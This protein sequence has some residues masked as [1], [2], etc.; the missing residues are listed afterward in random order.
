M[1]L[2]FSYYIATKAFAPPPEHL[3]SRLLHVYVYSAVSTSQYH[4]IPCTEQLDIK[5]ELIAD[6][7][8][9]YRFLI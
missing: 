7:H 1:R 5:L 8:W 3:G 6:V 4:L 2:Q 9:D